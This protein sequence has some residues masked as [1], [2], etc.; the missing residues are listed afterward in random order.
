MKGHRFSLSGE[1]LLRLVALLTAALGVVN[2]VSAVTPSQHSRLFLLQR[3]LPFVYLSSEGHLTAALAAFA[4][5]QLSVSLWRRKQLGWWLTVI[6]LLVSIPAHL[7]KG[8]DYEEALLA[9]LLLTLLLY[10]RPHFHARSDIPSI[11]QGLWALLA[12]LGF[13]LA[14]GV[15]GFYLLDHHYSVHFGFWTALRQTIVMFTQFYDPGLQPVTHFGKSFANSIYIISMITMTYA[16]LMVLRPVRVRNRATEEERT[17]AWEVVRMFGRSSLAR[18]AL[19]DDKHFFFSSTGALVSYVVKNRIALVLGDPICPSENAAEGITA[20]RSFC[21]HNDWLPVFYQVSPEYLDLYKA[22]TLNTLMIGHEAIVDVST[23]TLEGSANRTLRYEYNKLL[24]NGYRC[25]VVQPPFSPR[26]VRELASISN[27]WLASRGTSELHFSLGWF[28]EA[29]VQ[30]CP[31]L[32]IRDREGFIEAFANLVS[33]FQAPEITVDLMRHR[34]HIESG[35]MDF[36]FVSLFHWA[37]SNNYATVNL[38]LSA[39]SGVGE[40]NDDPIIERT[41]HYMYRNINHFYNFRGL[42]EYKN[43]FHPQ[44][45]PR[46]L[47]Y[48]V[49][50]ELPAVSLALLRASLD[51]TI[52]AAVFGPLR[53]IKMNTNLE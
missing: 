4:L 27:E 28:N 6:S 2:L 14:Y 22:A 50:A 46:Y 36:L 9:C 53:R 44:W 3:Y 38:G 40:H 5:L 10:L 7:L 24:R 15:I 26:L 17:R 11:R 8:L 32:L 31:I 42:H 25:D 39:L 20:F 13:T 29:Y 35:I 16:L 12:S 33:E 21:E 34:T 48:P 37:H 45:S 51:N 19:L 1:K 43:K 18:Y 41:L 47:I 49:A 52:L 23:F 30:T